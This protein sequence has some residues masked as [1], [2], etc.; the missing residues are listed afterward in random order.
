MEIGRENQRLKKFASGVKANASRAARVTM[1]TV[2]VKWLRTQINRTARTSQ[3]RTIRGMTRARSHDVGRP[4]PGRALMATGAW[5]HEVSR[6]ASAL[7]FGVQG[8]E[9]DDGDRDPD[10]GA[11][12]L[13]PGQQEHRW[14]GPR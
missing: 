9:D 5:S 7:A 8:T 13:W 1:R 14:P 11:E 4:L 6:E 2:R 12:A 3:A 10:A